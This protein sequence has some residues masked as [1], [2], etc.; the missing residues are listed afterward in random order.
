MKEKSMTTPIASALVPQS[1]LD[2]KVVVEVLM[3]KEAALR[4]QAQVIAAQGGQHTDLTADLDREIEENAIRLLEDGALA[5][6]AD[7]ERMSVAERA[8]VERRLA[9]LREQRSE[10]GGSAERAS[11]GLAALNR[12]IATRMEE[13]REPAA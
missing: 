1:L 12:L 5:G 11:A 7:Q 3:L 10:L 4:S 2:K 6:I 8:S 9:E 13:M